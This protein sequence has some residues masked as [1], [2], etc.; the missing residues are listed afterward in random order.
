MGRKTYDS[1]P[2]KLRPLGKRLNVVISRDLDGAV[3]R[4]VREELEGKL[5]R[6]KEVREKK[7]REKAE[8][9]VKEQ[10][11]QA[12]GKTDAFV[13]SSLSDALGR[14]DGGVQ[15]GNVG[16][17]F[18]IGGAEI[19]GTALKS[20]FDSRKVRIVM[21]EVEKI[22]GGGFECDTFFPV[23]ADEL[24]GEAWRK[25][26]PQEVSG[27]V[28]EEVKGEWIEEGEVKVRMMGYEKVNS[29]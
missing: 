6:E 25:V 5:G 9:G 17:L 21:T 22:S 23:D 2:L 28:G 4:R 24:A 19:Y 10:E 14:L 8:A 3:S 29:S 12:Q 7:A 15:G 1:V 20:G 27:W 18:V 16:N 26:S 11:G 13:A